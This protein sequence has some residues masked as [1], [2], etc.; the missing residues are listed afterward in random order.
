MLELFAY[1][2]I[3]RALIT[4]ILLSICCGFIGTYIVSRRIVFIAGGISHSA[5]GGIGM[6]Y[7]FGFNKIGGAAFFAVISAF[8]IE[9]L[10]KKTRMRIDSL[11]GIIWSL[12]MATGIFFIYITP[13]YA[14]GLRDLLFGSILSVSWQY[15]YIIASLTLAVLLFF[16]LFFKEILYTAFDE[17]FARTQKIP[18]NLINYLLL[19]L[20]ALTIVMA[21]KAVG[22]ILV[23]SLLTI[24]QAT[25]AILTSDYKKSIIASIILGIFICFSGLVL[26]HYSEIASGATIIFSAVFIFILFKIIKIIMTKIRL[27]RELKVSS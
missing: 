13:G 12:G 1:S 23:I 5:F 24:P 22:I 16:T 20:I 8:I 18:V 19:M 4:A 21:I 27:K 7:Y 9:L 25:A 14:P 3:I 11:I 15:L 26:E 6:G 10:S 17:E 2:F